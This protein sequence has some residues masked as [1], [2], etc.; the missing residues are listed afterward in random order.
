MLGNRLQKRKR[1]ETPANDDSDSESNAGDFSNEEDDPLYEPEDWDSDDYENRT[2]TSH[3][4][5]SITN[6]SGLIDESTVHESINAPLSITTSS[7][8]L[9]TVD[10]MR[11]ATATAV[12]IDNNSNVANRNRTIREG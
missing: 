1:I 8:N 7:N 12:N 6:Q 9:N 2:D 10:D 3:I 5:E 4:F 11:E